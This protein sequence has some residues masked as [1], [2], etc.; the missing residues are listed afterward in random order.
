MASLCV[1][2]PVGAHAE[3]GVAGQ[4]KIRSSVWIELWSRPLRRSSS[5]V[6]AESILKGQ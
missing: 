3:N 4:E 2:W 1:K 6:D 5:G